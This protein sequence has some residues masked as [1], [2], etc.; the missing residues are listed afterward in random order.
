MMLEY[1]YYGAKKKKRKKKEGRKG[2]GGG[3]G[4]GGGEGTT[5]SPSIQAVAHVT[6]YLDKCCHTTKLFNGRA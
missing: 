4:G 1:N 3:G 5:G 2:T 6:L